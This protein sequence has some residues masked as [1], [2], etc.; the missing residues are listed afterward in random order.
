MIRIRSLLIA[1]ILGIAPAAAQTDTPEALIL[2][3]QVVAK[4]DANRTAVLQAMSAPLTKYLQ[5]I[6]NIG[7][8][9]AQVLVSEAL[10]PLLDSNFDRLLD[11]QATNYASVLSLED[12]K[13]LLAFYD[14]TAGKDFLRLQPRLTQGTMSAV[15]QFLIDLKPAITLKIQDIIKAHGWSKPTADSPKPG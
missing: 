7:P 15:N 2:A 8:D 13:G 3:R 10:I 14:T 11:I 9:R 12:L 1:S 5:T 6:G 4:S